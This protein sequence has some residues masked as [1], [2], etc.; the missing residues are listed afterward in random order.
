MEI[1]YIFFNKIKPILTKLKNKIGDDF[2]IFGSAT[3]YLLKVVDYNE[4]INDIDIAVKNKNIIPKDAKKVL[5]RNDPNQELYKL[6]I[7]NIKVDIGSV[8]KGQEDYFHKLFDSPIEV[9]GF[10]FVNLK[11]LE[12]WKEK[13]FKKYG[14]EKD[15]KYLEKIQEYKKKKHFLS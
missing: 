12:E 2:I 4:N 5:F 11:T 10:K 3:L 6:T 13:T 9:D 15:G 7:D 14:R 1:D 8:W